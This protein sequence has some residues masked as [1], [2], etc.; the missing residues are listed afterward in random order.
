[1]GVVAILGR[2]LDMC[3]RNSDTALSFF[4]SLINRAILEEFS[5]SFLSL[6]L[7]NGSSQGSLLN[8]S[9]VK[10]DIK[11]VLVYLSVINVTNCSFRHQLWFSNSHKPY[12]PMFTCGFD[13]S[14]TAAYERVAFTKATAFC[15][16]SACCTG[17][18]EFPCCRADRAVR[19]KGLMDR[20]NTGIIRTGHK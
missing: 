13:R 6:S 1:M 8:E 11:S 4:G 7:R 16:R 5:E 9:E 3:G 10:H 19:R 17:L 14:N 15:R 12:I 18:T 2:V 20:P